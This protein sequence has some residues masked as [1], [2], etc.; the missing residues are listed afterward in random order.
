MANATPG[1]LSSGASKLKLVIA[2][3]GGVGAAFGSIAS[4]VGN[5]FSPQYLAYGVAFGAV[6]SSVAH[7]LSQTVGDSDEQQGQSPAQQN[8]TA[9]I[10]ASAIVQAA[11]IAVPYQTSG[12]ITQVGPPVT[13]LGQASQ[14]PANH[15]QV[16][17]PTPK[18]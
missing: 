8:A 17:S 3:L 5:A 7:A 4:V 2:V 15:T 16:T 14:V 9:A 6:C 10:H 13:G 1:T 11:P 12:Y 18:A